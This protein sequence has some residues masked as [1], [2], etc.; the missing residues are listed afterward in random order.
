[1]NTIKIIDFPIIQD[2]RGDLSFIEN[3]DHIPFAIKRV[4]YLYNV[5]ANVSRGGHAHKKLQQVLVAMSG[6]FD[7]SLD[8]GSDKQMVTLNSPAQGLLIN[9]PMWRELKNF[10]SDA[11]CVV[12][13]SELYT[14]DDYYRDYDNFL[15]HVRNA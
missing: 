12:L 8:D 2:S 10:S 1:M 9:H 11:V 4:Y 6:S 13:A 7:V 14:E 5:P 15:A 3:N